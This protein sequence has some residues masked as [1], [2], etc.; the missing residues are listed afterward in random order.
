M[1]DVKNNSMSQSSV[2]TYISAGYIFTEC[3]V[4]MHIFY[5]NLIYEK[6]TKYM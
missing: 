6:T 2:C 4:E 1:T 5:T 3:S